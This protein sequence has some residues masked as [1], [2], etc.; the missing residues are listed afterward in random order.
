MPNPGCQVLT[1]LPVQVAYI[2]FINIFFP[3]QTI[4]T[5][6]FL[7]FFLNWLLREVRSGARVCMRLFSCS[8]KID[9]EG[10]A[11][12][13]MMREWANVFG[14]MTSNAEM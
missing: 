14:A 11:R 3:A 2:C 9:R 1:C 12:N 7:L 10:F 6:F 4:Q 8:W 5:F 13:I